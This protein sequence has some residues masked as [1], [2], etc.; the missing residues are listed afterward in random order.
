[1][2]ISRIGTATEHFHSAGKSKR[3]IGGELEHFQ[4]DVI[5][6]LDEIPTDRKAM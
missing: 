6:R 1:M 2:R 5:L 4:T 3:R